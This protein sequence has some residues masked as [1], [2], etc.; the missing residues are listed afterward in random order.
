MIDILNYFVNS[1]YDIILYTGK[2]EK[3]Y[4][5]LS[6]KI[7]VR[8]LFT[9]KRNSSFNR[10][11]TWIIFFIQSLLLLFFDSNSKTKVYFSS[12]PPFAPFISLFYN[13]KYYI[14]IYDVYPDALLASPKITENSFSYKLFS[15]LNNKVFKKSERVLTASEGM[16]NMLEKYVNK[17]KILVVNWWADTDYIKPIKKEDN[18]FIE[19]YNLKDKFIVMYSGNFGFTHNIEKI[20]NLARDLKE[21]KDIMF[22]IIGDGPKKKI[23]DEFNRKNNLD[24]LLVLPFQ[25]EEM[26]PYSLASSDISIILDSF[27]YHD[28]NISTASIPSKTYYLMSAGSAIIAIADKHSELNRLIKEYN[29]GFVDSHEDNS[30]IIAFIKECIADKNFLKTFKIN[31]RNASKSFTKNNAKIIY[32]LITNG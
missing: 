21:Q 15:Y 12:N 2:I 7:K 28:K 10:I 31:S 25:D 26:L 29:I 16:K 8:K 23:V 1:S 20:L 13:L 14:H 4:S 3:T 6:N 9:Y 32:D 30:N 18:K 17:N 24:N 5:D 11:L 19:R 27:S 22:V